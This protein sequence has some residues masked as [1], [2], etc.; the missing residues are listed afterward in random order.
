MSSLISI[1]VTV[2]NVENYIEQCLDSIVGQTYRDLE[3]ILVDD[4]STDRSPAICDRY[5]DKDKRIRVI[6]KENEGLVR[7]RKTGIMAASGVYVG[8][9]DADDWIEPAMYERL[10]QCMEESRADLVASGR[11]E[12]Y[13]GESRVRKNKVKPGLYSGRSKNELYRRMI[14]SGSFFESGTNC[15]ERNYCFPI[16]CR[17]RMKLWWARMWRAHFR[18][19]L[20]RI[21][22]ISA[23]NVSIIT[24]GETIPCCVHRTGNITSGYKSCSSI[25]MNDADSS[26]VGTA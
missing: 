21:R 14:F 7:A 5:A 19:C 15:S 10:L 4:G 22:Y 6:H 8:Y 18:V 26:P 25:C 23:A 1:I 11:I 17:C 16:R 3:I 2:Y 20:K 13:P 9:V 24:G 12:E